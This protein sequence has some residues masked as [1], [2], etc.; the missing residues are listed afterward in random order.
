MTAKDFHQV[1]KTVLIFKIVLV[2]LIK[3]EPLEIK[4][5]CNSCNLCLTSVTMC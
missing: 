2:C 3:V 5:G 1:L 4:N